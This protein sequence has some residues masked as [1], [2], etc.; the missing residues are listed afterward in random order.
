M[1]RILLTLVI[2]SL[3]GCAVTHN[4]I[5]NYRNQCTQIGYKTG[6]NAHV[7]CTADRLNS[8]EQ[9]RAT[10]IQGFGSGN[11]NANRSRDVICRPWGNGIKCEEW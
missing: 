6:T 5:S 4:D 8:H 1:K 2:T 11:T 10:I 7:Q 3:T 9:R